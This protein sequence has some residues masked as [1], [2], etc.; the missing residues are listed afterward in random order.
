MAQQLKFTKTEAKNIIIAT[1]FPY[2][3]FSSLEI[4][5][6]LGYVQIDTLSVAER[7]HH[8]VLYSRNSDYTK[9]DLDNMMLKKEIFEYWS[10][11]ASYLPMNDYRFSLL[12]KREF[13]NGQS[14]WFVQNK[15]MNQYV[16]D[17]IKSEGALQSKDFREARDV[18][19][20]WYDWKPAKIALE[21]LFMEGKLMVSKRKN[22]QKVY[23][24]TERIVPT[25]IDTSIPSLH[26]YCEY[27]IESTLKAQGIAT[28]SEIGYLRKGIKPALVKTI[29]KL[30][31]TGALKQVQI[32]GI[33]QVYYITNR[34][35]PIQ[36]PGDTVHILSP[37]DNLVIQR[38]R[39][40]TLFDFDYQ[41]ECYVP[42]PKRKFG[43]FCL[44]VLYRDQFI[45]RFDPKA[46]RKTGVF[47]IK[48]LWFEPDFVPEE[49]FYHKFSEKLS[50]L[51]SFCG[52]NEVVI[53]TCFPLVYKKQLVKTIK[54]SK[55]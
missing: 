25:T 16:L 53:D 26:Q 44:P 24:L 14:H 43:Y 51:A 1:Q 40:K 22:F 46:D 15:K 29:K 52:C 4:I 2:N 19:T 37:F 9:S 7:S 28:L 55:S 36:E 11:A 17:R 18:P 5:Q 6:R 8:H 12:K 30:V 32:E 54:N 27:L 3:S 21:Q 23:D 33:S 34:S 48:K 49:D 13:A 10:H 31:N 45:A 38:K 35:S 50:Q 39:L 47:Q 41:I 42:E 20:A